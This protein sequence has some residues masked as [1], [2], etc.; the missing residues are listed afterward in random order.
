[1]GWDG[2]YFS[3]DRK[4]DF[5]ERI[6]NY[7][8]ENE[9]SKSKVLDYSIV[10]S[11]L[12]FVAVS[13]FNKKTK[14]TCDYIISILMNLDKGD[15]SIQK[16]LMFKHVSEEMGPYNF[17]CPQ[18]LLKITDKNKPKCEHSIEWRKSVVKYH[19]ERKK[20]KSL[21]VK[22][23]PYGKFTIHREIQVACN[24]RK[25]FLGK[26]SKYRAGWVG[27]NDGN[28]MITDYRYYSKEEAEKNFLQKIEDMKKL[29]DENNK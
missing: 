5:L 26:L 19:E 29:H 11:K 2:T 17:N 9:K 21:P 24:G 27:L 13:H 20:A 18:K 16:F 14:E 15:N 28:R 4:R 12:G 6:N 22:N 3:G 8:Y 10:S 25:Y 1:M 7:N 23:T